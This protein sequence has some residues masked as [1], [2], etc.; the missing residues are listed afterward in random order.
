MKDFIKG[1]VLSVKNTDTMGTFKQRG[2]IPL[3]LLFNAGAW[4]YLQLRMMQNPYSNL[5]FLTA[6]LWIPLI[7]GII[8]GLFQDKAWIQGGVCFIAG[9]WFW[10]VQ[11]VRF[12]NWRIAHPQD[13]SKTTYEQLAGLIVAG[14]IIC[15]LSAL[16]T[17]E[18]LMKI[19]QF[20]KGE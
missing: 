2:Y 13:L 14:G 15:C 20:V 17:S 16:I 12:H 8:T 9:G 19:R 7:S 1:N 6:I 18:I 5:P 11:L 10:A 3:V 4:L